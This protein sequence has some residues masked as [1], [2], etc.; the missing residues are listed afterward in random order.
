[1]LYAGEHDLDN[2]IDVETSARDRF[3]V[4]E[5]SMVSLSR[6][7]IRKALITLGTIASIS[8]GP[9]ALAQ[10]QTKTRHVPVAATDR[11]E[12][13][14][15]IANDLAISKMSMSMMVDP[16]G[17]IDRDFVTIM[18]PHQ[19]GALDMARAELKYG[20]NEE[21]RRLARD[22]I[23]EREHEILVMRGAIGDASP[24]AQTGDT[25]AAEST[26]GSN[27][28]HPSSGRIQE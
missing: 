6:S 1:V 8:A 7:F 20:H 9:L 24:P 27:S 11:S 26:T 18:I 5:V 25:P 15:I 14:F 13:Q 22:I 10:D 3:I 23:A 4:M 28:K 2:R 16:T 21:L 12:Q 19:Q 17:D